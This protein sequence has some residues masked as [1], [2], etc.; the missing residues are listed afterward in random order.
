MLV[1]NHS[2]FGAVALPEVHVMSAGGPIALLAD[3]ARLHS[4]RFDQVGGVRLADRFA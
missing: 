1:V 4:T 3:A 2:A